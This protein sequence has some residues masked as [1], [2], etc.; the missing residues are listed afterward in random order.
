MIFLYF[1][2]IE[3]PIPPT[4]DV[5]QVIVKMSFDAVYLRPEFLTQ[6]DKRHSKECIYD[7]KE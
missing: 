2:C 5:F 6:K 1:Y 3:N 7:E 4:A